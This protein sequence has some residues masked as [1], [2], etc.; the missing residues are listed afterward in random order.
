MPLE[1]D[2]TVLYVVGYKTRLLN[3]DLAVNSPY[4]TYIVHGLPPGPI[5]SPG[6]ASL[7][8][9]CSPASTGYLYYV[10]TGKDGSHTFTA[11]KAEFLAA[12]EQAKKGLR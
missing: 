10:R 7:E 1:I 11:T 4:N 12:K 3:R 5:A 9:A 8:A 6:L 2:A